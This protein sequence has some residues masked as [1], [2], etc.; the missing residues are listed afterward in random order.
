MTDP[1]ASA[2]APAQEPAPVQQDEAQQPTQPSP[3]DAP[4]PEAAK[5][6][7]PARPAFA[8][9]EGKIVTTFKGGRE[10]DQPWVVIHANSV[11]ESDALLDQ[12]FAD[13][14]AKVKRVASFFNGGGS[15]PAPSGGGQPQQQ[16]RQAPPQ[17]ANQ[18]PSWAP[19]KPFDDF[20]YVTK[21]SAKTGRPWHAWMAPE[22]ND[23]RPALFFNP[24]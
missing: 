19:P 12:A 16:N 3:W 21:V 7:A 6:A 9:A 18:P 23:P 20:V 14:L 17:G 2:P 22:K 15:A 24:K 5:P 11:E 4:P 13:Y 1:F 10:Y 8:D